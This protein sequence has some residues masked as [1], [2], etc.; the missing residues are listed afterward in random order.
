VWTLYRRAGQWLEGGVD[1]MEQSRRDRQ[2][3][4]SM[5]L[6]TLGEGFRDEADAHFPIHADALFSNV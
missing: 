4:K 2:A 6:E 1:A 5:V 3:Q